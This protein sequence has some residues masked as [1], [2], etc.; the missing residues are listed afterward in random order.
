[1][2]S[3]RA[4]LE[5]ADTLEYRHTNRIA[6]QALAEKKR[7]DNFLFKI[8]YEFIIKKCTELKYKKK[9]KVIKTHCS[10]PYTLEMALN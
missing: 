7:E 5:M 9:K 6:T 4:V 3:K 1:M 8:K 10:A 2:R